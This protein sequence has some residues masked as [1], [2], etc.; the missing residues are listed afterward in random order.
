[1]VSISTV[2]LMVPLRDVEQRLLARTKTSFHR[3]ASRWLRSWADRSR[4]R[5]RASKLL[6][7]V[8]EVEAEVEEAAGHRLAV[9]RQDVALVE[10]PAA[11]ADEEDGGVVD[12]LIRLP[13][14][15][16]V[17]GDG[18]AMASRD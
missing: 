17:E 13:V 16:S 14:V 10:V 1:M 12:Q 9:D 4:G 2:A 15:G 5:C 7:V 3:R 6:G 18:A 8:E 11:G